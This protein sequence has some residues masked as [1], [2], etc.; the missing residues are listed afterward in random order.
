MLTRTIHRASH[1]WATRP[2]DQRFLTLDSLYAA[3]S[4]RRD[5]SETHNVSVGHLAVM[6]TDDGM[7]LAAPGMNVGGAMTH[8]SFGQLCGHAKAPAGYLRKLPAGLA[9]IPLQWSLEQQTDDAQVL[10]HNTDDGAQVTALTSTTYGRIWNAPV[11][12]AI[13]DKLGK[14]WKVPSASYA[15][16]NPLRA[17]TLYASDRDVFV[18]LVNE[19]KQIKVGDDTFFRGIMAWNS[20][21]GSATLGFSQFLYQ[22]VCDNRIVWGVSQH[23]EIRVRHTAGGPHKFVAEVVPAISAY[24]EASDAAEIAVLQ[25]ARTL[26]LG[27]TQD[28]VTK[29]LAARGFNRTQATAIYDTAKTRG[30]D[31]T[32][33]WSAV[34]SATYL[35]ADIK[36][37]DDRVAYERTAGALL[38]TVEE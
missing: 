5:H 36:N 31:P 17:T 3:V 4:H 26:S 30:K 38:T 11:V 34:D 22:Y 20:E 6:P 13:R 19:E 1:E 18:F 2:N 12:A 33:L 37:A 23:K 29:W 8:W 7:R 24:A 14:G 25:K 9:A 21:V 15:S 16:S 10:V 32:T 28:D 27:A 35:A